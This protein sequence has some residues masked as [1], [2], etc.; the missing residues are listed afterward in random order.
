MKSCIGFTLIEG[1]VILAIVGVL[2]A[3]IVSHFSGL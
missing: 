1:L 3:I 2:V